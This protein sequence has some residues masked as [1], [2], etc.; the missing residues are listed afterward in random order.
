MKIA[1]C[2]EYDPMK[3]VVR[4]PS[5]YVQFVFVRGLVSSWKQPIFYGFD[6]KI[7]KDTLENI[8]SKLYSANFTVVEVVSDM[9]PSN[10][11][12]WKDIGNGQLQKLGSIILKV[13][14]SVY[15]CLLMHR[16]F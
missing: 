6:C 7:K 4:K 15:S 1:S 2:Y 16:T 5:N 8:S 10:Q 12:M 11:A 13:I 3:R 9:G 14:H